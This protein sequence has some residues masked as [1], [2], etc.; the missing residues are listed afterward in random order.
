MSRLNLSALAA[1]RERGE[2]IAM[3]T[4]YDA[5]FAA[6]AD[7]AGVDTLL[8]GD[9]LGNVIQGHDST[10]PVRIAEMAYHCACVA[11]GAERPFLI[12]DMPFMSY[13]NPAQA[14]NNAARLMQEG[15]A[16]M[17]KLEGGQVMLP[18]VE[19]LVGKGIPVC[20]HLG[21]TPQ[22]VHRLGGY[23]VQA[24]DESSAA[25]L[26]TDAR[27]LAAAGAQLLVLECIPSDVASA[28]TQALS[29]PTIGI[30]AG[31]DVG[32]QVLVMHDLLGM[33]PH[34]PRFVK[35]F[36]AGRGS[37]EAAFSAYVAA[38]KDGGFPQAEHSYAN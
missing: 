24:R 29:I 27:A 7:R 21:L 23:R 36:L 38:V 9:S 25:R 4:A 1:M 15:A 32:G 34:P 19:E 17:V 16:Q 22:S 6:A 30:G 12:A 5:S 31:A 2:K 28:V 8:V 18:I 26:L 3:L 13:Q 35:D 14:L 10:L 11:R 37:I 33:N 20:A